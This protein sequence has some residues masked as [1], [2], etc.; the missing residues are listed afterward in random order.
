VIWI[1][2]YK[3]MLGAELSALFLK[4]W[5]THFVSGRDVDITD[6][7]SLGAFAESRGKIDWIVNCAAY[8][9]AD[10]AEYNSGYSR[11]VNVDGPANAAKIAKQLKAKFVHISADS[12][13]D[14]KG[15]YDGDLRKLRPY[16]ENDNTNP[17]GIF[18][19]IKRD[20][21]QLV[22]QNNSASYIIR[23]AWLY[24][25]HG[26]N[27]ADGMLRLMKEQDTVYA[28]DNRRGSPTW[29]YNLALTIA[30]LITVSD[31]GKHIPYGIYHYTDDGDITLLNF[32]RKL[33]A[34]GRELNLLDR[35][36][37]IDPSPGTGL[38]AESADPGYFV[39]NKK[40]IKS[41]LRIKL[42]AW[43]SSLFSYMN[44]LR[45]GQQRD[46]EEDMQ[47]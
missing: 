8:T 9:P 3:G 18:G 21:E 34:L 27:F 44:S 46:D 6:I 15:I 10:S 30:A 7:E 5:V 4:L 43:D 12:V 2:G 33:Y 19:N 13:F 11:A 23:T 22:R 41:A 40:K 39:L 38:S 32:T 42:R 25:S 20:G 36:C 45:I 24:G 16:L 35:D 47:D 29:A 17:A 31:N 1:I 28:D 37:I 26:G 14:G